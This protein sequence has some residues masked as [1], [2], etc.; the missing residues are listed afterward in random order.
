[1]LAELRQRHEA[2]SDLL[3]SLEALCQDE[4][5]DMEKVSAVRLALTR[6]SRARSG[7]L[8]AVIYPHLAR[9]CPPD[10]RAALEKLKTEGLLMLVRSG[11]HQRRW[12]AQQIAVDWDGYRR[13]SAAA[14]QSMR[15]RMAREAE[16]I[17]PLLKDERA[18]ERR[19]AGETR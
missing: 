9:T 11:D 18:A 4:H 19:E 2:I 14:R 7:Y 15:E 1:M 8:N 5:P 17:Y 12:T 16:L 3:N 13:A 10:T 6:A